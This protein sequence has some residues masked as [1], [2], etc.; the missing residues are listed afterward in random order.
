MI[1]PPTEMAAAM[2]AAAM[3][4]ATGAAAKLVS[5]EAVG[6]EAN[7]FEAVLRVA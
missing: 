7:P 4:V 5:G 2:A 3:V 6:T 1:A